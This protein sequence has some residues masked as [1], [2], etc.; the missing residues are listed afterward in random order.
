MSG[1][2]SQDMEKL[3]K[4]RVQEPCARRV[5]HHTV[6][7]KWKLPKAIEGVMG[8]EILV[9][10]KSIETIVNPRRCMTVISCLPPVQRLLITIRTI[11]KTDLKCLPCTTIRYHPRDNKY[12]CV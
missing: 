9:D 7:L 10:G 6:S 1:S 8:Y 12:I 5:S 11:T 4:L 2:E 3:D